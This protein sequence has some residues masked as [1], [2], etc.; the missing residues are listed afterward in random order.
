MRSAWIL[1][2]FTFLM[3]A[4]CTPLQLENEE[5]TTTTPPPD[6]RPDPDPEPEPEPEPDPDPEPDPEPIPPGDLD[7]WG[8]M[9]RSCLWCH[10]TENP[11]AG[12]DF[13]DHTL[14]PAGYDEM[15][16]GVQL[17]MAPLME[18]LNRRDK[19][20]LLDYL[21]ERGANI[22]PEDI[23]SRYTWRLED[24]ISALPDGAPAPGF[25]F[26]IEDGFI[27]QQAW[28][29]DSYTDNHGRTYR[30]IALDQQRQVDQ[31]IFTSSRNP[32]SYLVFRGVPY[33][34]RFY[35]S[36]LE[37]DVRVGRWMSVGMGTRLM[38]PTGRAN[39]STCG[40]SSIATPSRCA[41]PQ[42]VSRRG[43]GATSRM[44]G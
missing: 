15:A 23:P 25:A 39:A 29:V 3:V 27:D 12:F 17:E 30:G 36:R 40:C 20:V 13:S 44:D 19:D 5:D 28:T 1:L 6:P 35:N 7:F 8:V 10:T 41:L 21:S 38:E 11:E 33:H 42:R 4:S 16:R 22:P 24:E 14:D 26:I 31:S 43:P 18:R 37:G 9:D 32:S 2:L 34:G